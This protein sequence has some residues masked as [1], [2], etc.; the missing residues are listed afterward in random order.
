MADRC[1]ETCGA[2]VS[3]KN[4]NTRFC[5]PCLKARRSAR[6]AKWKRRKHATDA[7]YHDR[8]KKEN[9]EYSRNR[10]ATDPEVR[11][12]HRQWNEAHK[13][14]KAAYMRRRRA[15]DPEFV[16]RER[17]RM[18]KYLPE[19][20]RRRR[21]ADP[22]FAASERKRL[23]EWNRIKY[24]SDPDYRRRMYERN[25]A[26]KWDATVN[27]ASIA[28]KLRA[29]KSKCAACRCYIGNGRYHLDH[30]LPFSKG[31]QSILANLQLLCP[32]CNSAKRDKLVY[33]GVNGQ[34]IMALG[35]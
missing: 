6:T 35:F 16:E 11:E 8:I 3:A 21:E 14:S 1:C 26:R 10:Y 17:Q 19:Y 4:A 29:Q 12:Y 15:T 18:R 22:E 23:R 30:I 24:A 13:D 31:G 5:A 33:E 7:E 34:M 9:R 27:P 32:P 20:F 25:I 28:E 2:D